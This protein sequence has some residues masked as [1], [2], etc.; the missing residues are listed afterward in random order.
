MDWLEQPLNATVFSWTRTWHRFGLT[1][2]LDLPYT[3]IVA[4]LEGSGI[5]LMGLLDDPDQVN[6][7]IGEAVIGRIGKTQVGD[8]SLPIIIWSRNA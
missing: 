5:R 2:G 1:D 3:N 4:E 8:R 7:A 6:P